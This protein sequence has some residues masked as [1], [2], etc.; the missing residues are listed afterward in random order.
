MKPA[1]KSVIVVRPPI[2]II[3]LIV[4]ARRGVDVALVVAGISVAMRNL[5]DGG[6]HVAT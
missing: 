1:N 4:A 3:L 6:A 5:H 2:G